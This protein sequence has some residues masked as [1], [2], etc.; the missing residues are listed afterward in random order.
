MA[1]DQ[2]QPLEFCGTLW[3]R[4]GGEA[5]DTRTQ[6]SASLVGLRLSTF[7]YDK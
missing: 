5:P 4:N 1:L 3:Y 7:A 2:I 6:K